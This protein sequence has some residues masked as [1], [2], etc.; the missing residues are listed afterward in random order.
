[1]ADFDTTV[2]ALRQWAATHDARARAAVELLCWHEHWLRR[3]DFIKAC[4]HADPHAGMTWINW[5]EA[6]EF[7]DAGP[8]ASTSELAIL[9]LA[10]TLGEDRFRFGSMGHAHRAAIVRAVALALGVEVPGA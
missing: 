1:M 5:R 8:R 6:R 4:V 10:L 9:D 3:Q 7:C 2:G